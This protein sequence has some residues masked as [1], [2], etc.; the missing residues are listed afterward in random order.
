MQ[1]SFLSLILSAL[2]LVS[3]GAETQLNNYGKIALVINEIMYHPYHPS[4]GAEDIGAE[5]IELLNRGDG[6]INL[7][8]W[9]LASG[10]DFVFGDVAVDAGQH[11]V[12]AADVETFAA[13]HPAVGNVVGGW[14]GRLSNSGETIEL[15]DN[16]GITVDSIRYADQG[17][18]GLRRLGPDDHGHRG[19]VWSDD[20][21]GGGKS[22][23][24]INCNV[25]NEHGQNWAAS[26]ADG[27][28][29]GAVNSIASDNIAPLILDVTHWPLIP[30]GD[31]P[32]TVSARIIDESTTA[33]V[34]ALHYRRDGDEAFS[35][36]T[37]SDDGKAGGLYRAEIPAQP[38]GTVVEFHVTT[39]DTAANWRTWPAAAMVDGT[40]QQIANALYQVNDSSSSDIS[41]S[42]GRQPVYHLIMTAE[43]LAELQDIGDR[44]Y[45]GNLFAGEAMSN[46]QMNATFIS[47]DGVDTQV[48]YGVGVRNR[49]N[50]KRADPPMSYHVNF[51][52]DNLWKGV[53]ALN[54]NNK[55]PHLELMGS[56]LLQNAGLPAADVTI[57]QLRVN[58]QN[59][60][61]SDYGRSYGAYAAIEVLDSDWAQNHFPDDAAGNLYRCTY[62]DDGV[63]SRTYADLDYKES[64]GQI[65]DPNNYRDNYPKKTN[66]SQDDWSDLF[67]LIDAL[68]NRNISDDDFVTEVDKVINLEKWMR[69]LAADALIG[70]REGGLTSG[71]GDDYAMYRGVK[72][73]RFWLVPHDLDTLLGQGD[74][75]YRPQLD[76][77][78]Y[79]SVDGLTRLLN[80]PDI[81][82]LYY[83]QYK[84]LAESVFAPENAHLLID[85][86]LSDWVPESEIEGPRG[87]KQFVI[88]RGNSI[89]HGGYPAGEAPQIPQEFTVGTNLPVMK[90]FHRTRSPVT[91]ISGTVNAI[92]TRSVTVNGY[93][94]AESD[95]S[96][97][98]GTWF[99]DNILLNPGINRIIVRAFDDPNGTGTQVEQGYIDIWYDTGST[100]DYPRKTDGAAWVAPP[101]SGATA[102][103]IVRDSYLPGTPILVR[104]ELLNDDGTINRDTWDAVA[105]L[106]V[107]DN[108]NIRL[109]TDQLIM[110]NGL[111]SALVTITGSGAFTLTVEIDGLYA[112]KVLTDWSNSPIQTVSGGLARSQTWTGIYRITGGDF[113]IPDGVIL[114]LDPGTLVLVDGVPSGAGGS[115]IDVEGS[116]QSLGT[117][118]SPVTIT[119]YTSGENWG[120]LHHVDA[121]PSTFLYTN[122]TQAGH[123]PRVGHSNSGPAIRASNSAFVFDHASLTDNAGKLM[124]VTSGSDLTFHN[125]LFARSIMGPEIYRTALLFE[126]SWITDMHADDDADGIYIHGQQAHQQCSLTRCVVADID[127]D[128]IDT[129][130]SRVTIQD[131]IVRDC[132][133]KGISV[134][135]GQV[136][137]DCCLI[138][139]N[140][141]APEDPTV[142]T[143]ATKTVNGA[144]AVVNIDHSTIVSTKT[145]GVVD[146]G[147]QSH[148]KYGVTSGTI[149]YN[150]TNSIIDA[151]DPIDVQSPYLESDIHVNYSNVFD[152]TW[153]GA[154]NLSADPMFADQTYHDYRLGE[155]SPSI[156]AGDPAAATDPDMTATDQGYCWQGGITRD[157][158]E[159]ALTADTIWTSQD[160]PYRITGALTVPPGSELTIMP[161]TSV[162]FDPD[163]SMTIEGRLT[164]EGTEY[165]QIRF[166]RTPGAAGAWAGLQFV[167]NIADNRI[168]HSVVEY[169]RTSNGM[170][171]LENSN[172]LLDHVTLDN[173]ILERIRAVNSSLIVSNSVFTD[174]CAPPEIPTDNRSEHIVARGIAADGWFI[175]ENNV[176]GRTPGHNDAID[177]D[178]PSRP[179][180]IPQIINNV[181]TGGG[182]D[183]LDLGSDAHIEGNVFMNYIK[184]EH[185]K[186]S[187]ESN[188]IS[189]GAGKHYVT[190][191]NIFYNVHHVAQ[192]K[193]DAFL[194]F[195]NN[196]VCNT[197]GPAI[198]F[199]L[200]LPGRR[201]GRGASLDGNIF[202]KTS[203]IFKGVADIT[204]LTINH[205]L[206][207]SEW[208]DL[209]LGNIDAD[210]LFVDSDGDFR[211]RA[212]S[213]AIGAGPCGLDMGAMVPAGAAICGEPAA[214]TN[215]TD[216]V[217]TVG[218]PGVTD[219]RYRLG[220]GPWS[221]QSPVDVPIELANLV[222][223]E[224]YIVEVIGGNSAGVWQSESNPTISK[225]W[226]VDISH[227]AL[228]INEVLAINSA[229]LEH[230]GVFP[231]LVE[232]YY[233]G[234]SALSLAGMSLT[235]EPDDPAK[236]VFAAG[237]RIEPGEYLL[238]YGG[239][240][241]AAS[242]IHL[243]FALN[244]DGEAL[245]LYDRSGRLLDS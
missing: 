226:T 169:G 122:I 239:S 77:F 1:I 235:D 174:T 216:A 236:F 91:S 223:G 4:P 240:G 198:Y 21:D 114:T 101:G 172:L 59:Q 105:I 204:D 192:V 64:P 124:D 228:I 89:L 164:A 221:E 151:S 18:W 125:C 159:G 173:T 108:P 82:K 100:N 93:A 72:D 112:N 17:D 193:D 241:P 9:R 19:W 217:L 14:Q 56:V 81:I 244:G 163:A 53:S 168:I 24:L 2:P 127:D 203:S 242:G 3:A 180:P 94:V 234:P 219:Y 185:N 95:F 60:A 207:P 215:R 78:V 116:I 145:A 76:I 138:V 28:T 46:A 70:N 67:N 175:V 38:D 43:E 211:L 126:N 49:G 48:R 149:I 5:Y 88:D 208:H 190:V 8:D 45:N 11:L 141:K 68:N 130:N 189:A 86:F 13:R 115:D 27:G 194:T 135:G 54:L 136:D 237:T 150:V 111:G 152:E 147:I 20:H 182:D 117:A 225:A 98:Y 90:G 99:I 30:G 15:V 36:V 71:R 162:F 113:K 227:S 107:E 197:F 23:E 6:T 50:R 44:D 229:T 201:P 243:G 200:G 212:A 62:H 37:M 131:V 84:D 187:G 123:S 75:D 214:V 199:D 69:H 134:Y 73:P 42:P 179:S 35:M 34:V 85:R 97:R 16:M 79:A 57:V 103:L 139:E 222:D 25:P 132:K 47:V 22:L 133:D 129:L 154:G 160:G 157:P 10:V 206:L 106:S 191:R 140:N 121:G 110:Y 7:S 102:N 26:L 176:F 233:D 61:A 155:S 178:G 195:E 167:N 209:G 156:D 128:G 231:D 161:G 205:S 188:A 119:A 220:E 31:E 165:E 218:G 92:T 158:P 224:S 29:P 166:T 232:L 238:L 74:H 146:V 104:V 58:G 12:V 33:T 210:P 55:Y 143:I 230:E 52:H 177:M 202:W 184:D 144:T 40:P 245:Y 196:S 120:E 39:T 142:A 213:P 41:W 32:V 170:I 65:P 186:A 183:A 181:F 63:H 109:S 153:P 118:D 80:N 66:I 87:I 51:R 96:Q 83:T 148:N 137:I 171:G